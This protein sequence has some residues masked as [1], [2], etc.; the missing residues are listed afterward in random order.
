VDE[1]GSALCP[2]V[3]ISITDIEPLGSFNSVWLNEYEL[4]REHCQLLIDIKL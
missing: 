1:S 2:V 4:T 3:A